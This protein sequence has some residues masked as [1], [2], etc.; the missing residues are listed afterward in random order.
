LC[1]SLVERA[2]G[3]RTS[4]AMRAFPASAETEPKHVL[5]ALSV[6]TVRGVNCATSDTV[7]S[8]VSCQC[9]EEGEP[10]CENFTFG[11]PILTA[12]TYYSL[13]VSLRCGDTDASSYLQD[14]PER[15]TA[16]HC[17]NRGVQRQPARRGWNYYTV[18]QRYQVFPVRCLMD[19]ACAFPP[20]Q[21]R[22]VPQHIML[23]ATMYSAGVPSI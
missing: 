22:L 8:F 5:K 7:A 18:L 9:C 17:E 15:K 19:I 1:S 4:F 6:P 3:V 21:A 12:L 14:V 23:N 16:H 11:D 20:L 2:T 10:T 13:T